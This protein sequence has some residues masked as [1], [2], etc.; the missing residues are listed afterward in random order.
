MPRK[1]SV[2]PMHAAT[3]PTGVGMICDLSHGIGRQ[4]SAMLAA[5]W[6]AA[7]SGTTDPGQQA[8]S[9][10]LH[11]SFVVGDP[12]IFFQKAPF[13]VLGPLP[14]SFVALRVVVPDSTFA[15]RWWASEILLETD[16]GTRATVKLT[17]R[18]CLLPQNIG[19]VFPFTFTWW[20]CDQ[21]VLITNVVLSPA[22]LREVMA[23]AGGDTVRT[24]LFRTSPGAYYVFRVDV[25]LTPTAEAVQ[26]LSVLSEATGAARLDDSPICVL[27]DIVPQPKCPP[28]R[29][30]ATRPY[31][32]DRAAGGDTVMLRRGGWVRATYT[33][34]DGSTRTTQMTVAK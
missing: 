2:H 34:P 32:F 15:V 20:A 31:V 14:D 16:A 12:E 13:A 4:C 22:R 33:Q 3:F 28:W 10:L 27:S 6:M 1:S 7:C 9:S 24:Y 19:L 29:L 21:V 26:R 17:P 11:S 18:D 8:T 30:V 23:I 25:G 5:C